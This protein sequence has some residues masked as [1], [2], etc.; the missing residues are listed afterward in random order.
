MPDDVSRNNPTAAGITGSSVFPD[1]VSLTL[2]GEV[3]YI[4]IEAAEK[5]NI[6]PQLYVR[7]MVTDGLKNAG[8][9]PKWWKRGKMNV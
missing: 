5:L 2:S 9:L 4:I 6:K 8:L 7:M 1:T 3:A